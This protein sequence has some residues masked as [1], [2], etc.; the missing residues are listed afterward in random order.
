[1]SQ[2]KVDQYKKEK[3]NRKSTIARNKAVRKI[4]H[5]VEIIVAIVLVVVI[6]TVITTKY[7]KE[8]YGS[9][10]LEKNKTTYF[11]D[12]EPMQGYLSELSE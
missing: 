11:V 8:H 7:N 3:A 9:T 5:A 2:Q 4:R 1:M 12:L 10:K 6:A